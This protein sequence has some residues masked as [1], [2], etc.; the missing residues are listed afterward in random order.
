MFEALIGDTR[1]VTPRCV[2]A[3][4]HRDVTET[5]PRRYNRRHARGAPRAVVVFVN[6]ER[7]GLNIIKNH[8][9]ARVCA[10]AR[11]EEASFGARR[12]ARGWEG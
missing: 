4:R 7:G 9:D 3:P 11:I 2:T 8:D 6:V 5:S 10:T 12:G 1:G